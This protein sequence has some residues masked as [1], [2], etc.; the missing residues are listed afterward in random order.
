MT[1]KKFP[2][3][4]KPGEQILVDDGKLLFEVL[5]TDGKSNVKTRVMRDGV[6]KSKKGVNLP[7]TN[8]SLPALTKKDTQDALFA[9]SL[10][11]DWFA[12]SFVRNVEDLDLIN[13]LIKENSTSQ[14]SRHR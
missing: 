9:I 2:K 5:E 8:V 4:V 1:Y 7:N 14:N 10:E 3:D 6:L 13:N 12:L 11:V